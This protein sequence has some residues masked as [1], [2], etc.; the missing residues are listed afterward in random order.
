M[1][2]FGAEVGFRHPAQG[3]QPRQ[4]NDQHSKRKQNERQPSVRKDPRAA[5]R[6]QGIT[7]GPQ[8][9]TT[10]PEMFWGVVAS[11][12]IGN[13]MLVI[14]NLPLIGV[15]VRFLKIPY[16][17]FYPAILV[18][19]CIGVYSVANSTADLFLLIV[20]G[21][22]GY[23]LSKWKCEA[24]PLML[25]FVL[26]PMMEENFRRAMQMARGDATVF[27]TQPISAVLLLLSAGLLLM[28]VLPA[29]RARR[30]R[31]SRRNERKRP[32]RSAGAFSNTNG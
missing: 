24:T 31:R 20:F 15:W 21:L 14:I 27:V 12:L 8:I 2:L 9:L 19:A 16:G 5:V 32:R 3:G 22:L 30:T 26:G 13:A 25:A 7:P 6:I 23:L 29:M 17:L 4:R 10:H 1:F 18:F 11:M 28:V